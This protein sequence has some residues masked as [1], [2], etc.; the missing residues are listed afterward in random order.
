[1]RYSTLIAILAAAAASTALPAAAEVT[2]R[3]MEAPIGRS[4]ETAIEPGG[5]MVDGH[6]AVQSDEHDPR[7][8]P[9]GSREEAVD[10]NEWA[11]EPGTGTSD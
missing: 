4:A 3:E 1:M 9:L 8:A 6:A 11:A 7:M 5:V 10:V 2:S